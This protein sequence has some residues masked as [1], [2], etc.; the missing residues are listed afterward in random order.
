[1]KP[2]SERGGLRGTPAQ[3]KETIR[4]T[5]VFD[6]LEQV[7][8]PQNMRLA[9]KR[10]EQ[11]KGSAGGDGMTVDDLRPFLLSHWSSLRSALLAGTYRPQPV[12]RVEIPKPSG[13]IRLLGIPTVLDRLIQ[14]A[15]G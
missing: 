2:E 13:G 6:L 12:K 4:E 15:V 3:P 1:V 9:L 5:Q 11:N 8:A 10:V 7:V 14:Q